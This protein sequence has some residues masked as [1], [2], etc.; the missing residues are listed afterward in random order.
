MK[1]NCNPKGVKSYIAGV[2]LKVNLK[3]GGKARNC[4]SPLRTKAR[5]RAKSP[6][7]ESPRTTTPATSTRH[8]H[9]HHHLDHHL[10]FPPLPPPPPPS[11]PPSPPKHVL[12]QNGFVG[13]SVHASRSGLPLMAAA[14]TIVFGADVHHASPGSQQPS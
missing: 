14:P 4:V 8:R 5:A 10:A 7:Q 9:H 1:K 13:E 12:L 2:L 6:W 3:L 11:Q